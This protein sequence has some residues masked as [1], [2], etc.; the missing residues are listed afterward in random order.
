MLLLWLVSFCKNSRNWGPRP[1]AIWLS[2]STRCNLRSSS[3]LTIFGS[4]PWWTC[5]A[6]QATPTAQGTPRRSSMSSGM[7]SSSMP[8]RPQIGSRFWPPKN[9]NKSLYLKVMAST[10]LYA[11]PLTA[12][13]ILMLAFLL[14]LFLVFIAYCPDLKAPFKIFWDQVHKW[15]QQD[16]PCMVHQPI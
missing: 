12:L 2:F 14:E 4:R 6:W 13:P 10:L 1:L 9:R 8:W 3:S 15:L 5:W 11:I 7:R 16:T